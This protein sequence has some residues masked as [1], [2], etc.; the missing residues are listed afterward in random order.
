MASER[1]AVALL[2]R[3]WPPA[4]GG[5]GHGGLDGGDLAEPA[6]F[7]GLLEVVAGGQSRSAASAPS[8]GSTPTPTRASRLVRGLPTQSQAYVPGQDARVHVVGEETYA[9][10][11]DSDAVDYRYAD[12]SG[13]SVLLAPCELPPETARRCVELV[14]NLRDAAAPPFLVRNVVTEQF[15]TG[16]AT[17][18]TD[19]DI[20]IGKLHT[21]GGA[22][23]VT[24]GAVFAADRTPRRTLAPPSRPTP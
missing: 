21:V 4:F 14:T 22:C 18:F 3:A 9:T 6:L 8:S 15:N 24:A 19:A 23:G 16:K 17:A 12:Q 2:G 5:G 1:W 10:A 11:V 13:E 20:D 7:L